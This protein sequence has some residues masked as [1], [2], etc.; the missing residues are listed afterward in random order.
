MHV[1]LSSASSRQAESGGLLPEWIL[2]S[3]FLGS[4]TPGAQGTVQR[5]ALRHVPRMYWA[6]LGR[7]RGLN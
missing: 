6:L 7:Y 5:T 3:I 4:L 2:G 1:A